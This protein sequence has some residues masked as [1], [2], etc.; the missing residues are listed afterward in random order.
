MDID[1]GWLE[2]QTFYQKKKMRFLVYCFLLHFCLFTL[3][4]IIK[5]LLLR[6]LD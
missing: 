5:Q 6:V 2:A 3:I 1:Q 4:I